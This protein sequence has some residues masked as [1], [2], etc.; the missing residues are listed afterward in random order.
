MKP[1]AIVACPTNLGLKELTPGVEPGVRRL[2]AWLEQHGLYERLQVQDI[3]TLPAPAYAM[4]IDPVSGVR[5]ADAIIAYAQQQAFLLQELLDAGKFPLVIGGD[6][7]IIIGNMLALK[8]RGRYGLFFLDGHTDYMDVTL[9]GTK[10]AAGMDLSIVTG[11][12]HDKLAN[13][14][15]AGPYVA[16]QDA[17][18]VGNRC[19]EVAYV[20]EILGSGIR[21]VDLPALRRMGIAQGVTE[22]LHL[23]TASALDGF[24]VHVDVDVLNNDI[25]PAV[26][27]P[28]DDGL[29]YE[30]LEELLRLLLQHPQVTGMDI[31]ILDPDLDPT[32]TYTRPFIDSLV[33]ILGSR[34]E[35]KHL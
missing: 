16:E 26:D 25:M 1:L 2:P 11:Y 19:Q 31:S 23:I 15:Q 6:C 13:M 28:Q 17:W 4:D 12:A 27:S 9:S 35:R 3:H 10:A 5:N 21:Y 24:W 14:E 32:G 22:F 29:H 33:R 8:K 18:A 34:D 30:E 20:N 7:S